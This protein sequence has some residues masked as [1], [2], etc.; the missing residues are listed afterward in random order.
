MRVKI[1]ITLVIFITITKSIYA[2]KAGETFF[3]TR[4][5][6]LLDSKNINYSITQ[7]GNFSIDLITEKAPKKR[8]QRVIIYSKISSYYNIEILN[9]ESSAFTISKE[10]IKTPVLID[11]LK[12][13]GTIK[14]GAWSIYEYDSD[15]EN[16]SFS[17]E[18]KVGYN[19]S[20]EELY[21]LINIVGLQADDKEKQWGNGLDEN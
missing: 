18:V 15:P 1:I 9:I 21:S 12:K 5:K 16:Y 13:N 8:T 10:N 3:D 6:N 7:N 20:A 17:F 14:I 4:I 2:Q 11:L 19:I